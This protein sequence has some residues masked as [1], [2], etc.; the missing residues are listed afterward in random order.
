MSNSTGPSNFVETKTKLKQII[1]HAENLEWKIE[2]KKPENCLIR[3][4]RDRIMIDVWYSKM[5][6]GIYENKTDRYFKHV[7][8]DDLVEILANPSYY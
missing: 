2:F 8:M 5:T 4:S 6:V 1:E 3:F 7:P